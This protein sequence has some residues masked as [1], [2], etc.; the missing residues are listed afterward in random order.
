MGKPTRQQRHMKALADLRALQKKYEEATQTV[1][2]PDVYRNRV[3]TEEDGDEIIRDHLDRRSGRTPAREWVF[4]TL[5]SGLTFIQAQRFCDNMGFDYV[6]LGHIHKK[7]YNDYLGQ[8]IVY[9]GSTVSLG[10]DEL[11]PR[12]IIVRRYSKK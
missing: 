8:N 10:F 4:A 1:D 7:S 5:A 9:P 2:N 3:I 12:G 11:G 6:A